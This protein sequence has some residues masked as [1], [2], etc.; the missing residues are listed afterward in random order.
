MFLIFFLPVWK[1]L[2]SGGEFGGA[3]VEGV[4]SSRVVGLRVAV[5]RP[6]EYLVNFI[7]AAVSQPS[8]AP[9]S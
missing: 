9:L 4:S 8:L 7:A 2:G 3:F 5:G 6:V 1:D